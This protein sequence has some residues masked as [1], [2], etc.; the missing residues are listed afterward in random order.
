MPSITLSA[1]NLINGIIEDRLTG[2]RPGPDMRGGVISTDAWDSAF[3]T[4]DEWDVLTARLYAAR[5]E[6]LAVRHALEDQIDAPDFPQRPDRE[7]IYE[8]FT[9]ACRL[10]TELYDLVSSHA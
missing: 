2:G 4:T 6:A 3:L 7:D 10:A 9:G 1:A 8:R 5:A